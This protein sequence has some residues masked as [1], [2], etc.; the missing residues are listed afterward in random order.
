MA[1]SVF[2]RQRHSIGLNVCSNPTV[3]D[4]ETQIGQPGWDVAF[5]YSTTDDFNT[6]VA[7]EVGDEHVSILGFSCHGSFDG[8][9]T[10]PLG[11]LAIQGGYGPWLH[12]GNVPVYIQFLDAL[13]RKLERNGIVYF[14]GCLVGTSDPG[15]RLLIRI[16]EILSP[17]LIVG[18]A[19][20]GHQAS[21]QSRPG[22][23]CQLPGV[24]FGQPGTWGTY[25][26]RSAVLARNNR[27]VPRP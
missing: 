23:R 7:Q 2:A 26:L 8:S 25:A 11:G 27:I 21:R 24:Q 18:F 10:Y 15:R 1:K 14:Y 12:V 20:E 6:Q 19:E 13:N 9:G 16:S 5:N 3:G 4:N 17:R 22:E